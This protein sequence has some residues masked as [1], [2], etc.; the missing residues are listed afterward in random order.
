MN[1]TMPLTLEESCLKFIPQYLQ[2]YS[3]ADGRTFTLSGYGPNE[4]LL[5]RILECTL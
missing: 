4:H 2:D 3:L 1:K 5:S